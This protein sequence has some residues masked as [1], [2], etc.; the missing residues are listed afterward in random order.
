VLETE[1]LEQWSA[2]VLDCDLAEA[3]HGQGVETTYLR[4]SACICGS[5]VSYSRS[6]AAKI[7]RGFAVKE[8][9]RADKQY[10]GS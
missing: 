7:S 9:K 10:V 8:C 6:F 2:A 3:P 5:I 4:K 1:A